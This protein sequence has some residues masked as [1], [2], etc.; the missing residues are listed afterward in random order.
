MSSID[1]I[2]AWIVKIGH[3]NA[4]ASL[5]KVSLMIYMLEMHQLKLKRTRQPK[6]QPTTRKTLQT[7]HANHKQRKGKERRRK[8]RHTK[9]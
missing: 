4:H 1:Q 6:L 2:Y 5:N 9:E 8:R 3:E 7:I